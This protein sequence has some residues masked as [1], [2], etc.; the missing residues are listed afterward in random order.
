MANSLLIT[1]AQPGPIRWAHC[2]QRFLSHGLHAALP[3]RSDSF[4][5]HW[6]DAVAGRSRCEH[7]RVFPMP[8][9]EHARADPQVH[10]GTDVR[11]RDGI[12]VARIR[13]VAVGLHPAAVY[14]VRHLVRHQRQRDQQRFLLRFEHRRPGPVA[15]LERTGIVFRQPGAYRGPQFVKRS[16]L[17]V[18]HRAD[19]RHRDVP[20]GVLRGRLVL[21]LP[22]PSGQ[23][24]G[25]IVLGH[26]PVR[27]VQ[28]DL[29][30]TWMLDHAGLQVVAHQA[31]RGSAEPFVHRHMGPQPRIL[32]HIQG[33]FH[34]RV[35]TERQYRHEQVH[36]R[37]ITGDR[38]DDAHG[39]AGPVDLDGAA[40]LMFHPACHAESRHVRG[41]QL[42][43]PVITHMGPT[44]LPAFV[45][46]LA[47]QNPQRHADTG[48]LPVDLA[49]VGL[50]IHA[51]TF[52]AP[53][54]QQRV[55]LVVRPVSDV[56]P[57]DAGGLRCVQHVGHAPARHALGPC[58]RAS[59]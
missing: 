15:L 55:Y 52:P 37:R 20:H 23:Y 5:D 40:G 48:Q 10:R 41:V 27:V 54:E 35:P 7:N 29:A 51:L 22:H 47:V 25:R 4:V 17:V 11:V 19:Q 43:E 53:G 42:A 28:H 58:D 32:P 33:G 16:E 39:L 49:P 59:R 36:G 31:R 34:E 8:D 50:L 21:R 46:I 2:S 57:A 18:A 45:H 13:D 38:I 9:L 56:I 3:G 12:P 24:S 1:A 26:A 44:R 6:L 14:P 30:L